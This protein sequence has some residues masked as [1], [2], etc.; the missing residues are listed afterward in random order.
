M[1]Q[2]VNYILNQNTVYS[3]HNMTIMESCSPSKMCQY[4]LQFV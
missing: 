1:I 4:L 3:N 2:F